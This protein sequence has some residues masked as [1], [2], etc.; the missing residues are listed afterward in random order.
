MELHKRHLV[1]N[2]DLDK[3]RKK[4][5]QVLNDKCST[6]NKIDLQFEL[7]RAKALCELVENMYVHNDFVASCYAYQYTL[8]LIERLVDYCYNNFSKK[9]VKEWC[10]EKTKTT[11]IKNELT[12]DVID[13][14]NLGYI[15]DYLQMNQMAIA[16]RYFIKYNIQYLERDKAE[17][18][19]PNRARILESFIWWVNQGLL[20]LFDLKMPSDTAKYD[21]K[22]ETIIFST[23]PSSGKS[24][25]CN[26]ANQMFAI[27][28]SLIKGM[29]GCLRIGNEQGN[30]F[31]QSRQT[32]NMIENKLIFDIYPELKQYINKTSGKYRPFQKE[33]EEEWGMQNVYFDPAT[34]V[35]K[36]RDSS[37][38]SVRC[39]IGMMD[40][41]SRGLQECNNIEIHKKIN[42]LYV[43][44]FDDRFKSQG[45]K[46]KILTGT[47]YNPFDVFAT[48]IESSLADG[49]FIDD[50][51][52]KTEGIG[53]D[54]KI[55]SSCKTLISKDKKTIVILNDIEDEEGN[56][57]FPEF[58]STADLQKKKKAMDAYT[59][60]CV[61]RQ[62]PIPAEGLIFD[63][64]LLRIEKDLP[65]DDLTQYS[66][67]YIDP[68]RKRASDFF[69][70][71][72]CR[73]HKNG[74]FYLTDVVYGRKA[75]R[76]FLDEIINKIIENKIIKIVIEK[77][78]SEDLDLLLKEKLK[79]K[80]VEWCEIVTIY[81]TVNKAQRIADMAGTVKRYI[82]FPPKE[83][84]GTKTPLGL[85]IHKLTEYSTVKSNDYDD[86][87]DSLCGFCQHF[88]INTDRRNIV[89]SKRR[90]PF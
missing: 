12:G 88:I 11:E 48:Q 9:D 52:T 53:K 58:I 61:W 60:A 57:A 44:D 20:G 34:C 5:R 76:D 46:L 51:F 21:F 68:T 32:M 14:N 4:F 17:K 50:R 25:V 81:N 64:N 87:P 6:W 82:I 86:A 19:Y 67:A 36:T 72:I 38:N 16:S 45:T 56:S 78:V 27:L 70:M 29:G 55:I 10:A 47:M 79:Q 40:D 35:F 3:L 90:L 43:G 30:I 39:Q 31:R 26:T 80:G 89:T 59:Y 15:C 75:S 71:P 41:P 42:Q 23:F 18:D 13:F 37:I 24:Y 77:N 62:K 85:F 74:D 66:F 49:Y 7:L 65:Y 63:Y 1:D 54:I 8:P 84:Y 83:K 73:K 33:S 22:P 28:S 69:S 2:E